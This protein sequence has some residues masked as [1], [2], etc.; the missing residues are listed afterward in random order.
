MGLE[1]N[2]WYIIQIFPEEVN[3]MMISKAN[4][5]GIVLAVFLVFILAVLLLLTYSILYCRPPG[6]TVVFPGKYLA[7]G[8]QSG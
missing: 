6:F 3:E 8:L 7:G 1:N 5:L 2:D 4:R